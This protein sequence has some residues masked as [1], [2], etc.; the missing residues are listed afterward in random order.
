MSIRIGLLSD[1]HAAS[2]PVKDALE[3][4]QQHHVDKVF[5]AGDIAGYGNQLRETVNLLKQNN[6]RSVL[7]NH[8]YWHLEKESHDADDEVAD[9]L[10]SLPLKINVVVEDIKL[11]MVHANPS[12]GL[13]DGIRLLDEDGEPVLALKYYWTKELQG[14]PSNILVV[15]HTH[16]VYV[17]Q[18]GN[19]L[20]INPGSTLF[21]HTCAI[22]SLPEKDVEFFALSGKQPVL[23]WNFGMLRGQSL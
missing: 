12:G 14:D 15:G 17:E 4:F 6:C 21:N 20:V 1:V 22:L 16:Q 10:Q 8:D 23:S 9:F 7:G 19:V 2:A 3:I 13:L 18:L 5:C 11:T